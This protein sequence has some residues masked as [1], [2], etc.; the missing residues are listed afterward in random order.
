MN[1]QSNETCSHCGKSGHAGQKFCPHCGKPSVIQSEEVTVRKEQIPQLDFPEQVF[2]FSNNK[3]TVKGKETPRLSLENLGNDDPT[4]LQQPKTSPQSESTIDQQP[5]DPHQPAVPNPA[6]EQ[7]LIASKPLWYVE[8]NSQPV[9]NP[10]DTQQAGSGQQWFAPQPVV[11]VPTG[12]FASGQY[13]MQP[14]VTPSKKPKWQTPVII[15]VVVIML[16]SVIGLIGYN[17]YDA[18]QKKI[19]ATATAQT[20]QTQ[21]AIANANA[22]ATQKSVYATATAEYNKNPYA[23]DDTNSMLVLDDS[24]QGTSP[25][26]LDKNSESGTCKLLYDGYHVTAFAEEVMPCIHLYSYTEFTFSIDMHLSKGDCGGIGKEINATSGYILMGCSDGTY[27]AGILQQDKLV[28][29]SAGSISLSEGKI[30]LAMKI[31]G[32]QVQAFANQQL[33]TSTT[34]AIINL[35]G[36]IG[37]VSVSNPEETEAVFTN[38]KLWTSG[39]SIYNS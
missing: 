26:W 38:A 14:P 11:P 24:L 8:Q 34:N 39:S 2:G 19:Q 4:V 33:V 21:T 17:Q 28:D 12:Q 31:K 16:I 9:Q 5:T 30:T 6:N 25:N 37:L 36:V 32:N 35:S 29:V 22:T 7:T 3:S 15:A 1:S 20:Q 18:N 13:P 10:Y 23:P 27:R